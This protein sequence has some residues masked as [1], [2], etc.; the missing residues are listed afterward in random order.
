MAAVTKRLGTV[1]I[2]GGDFDCTPEELLAIWNQL[3]MCFSVIRVQ[4]GFHIEPGYPNTTSMYLLVTISFEAR[5]E[6][7]T[8]LTFAEMAADETGM[9]AAL[10]SARRCG[11]DHRSDTFFDRGKKL[12]GFKSDPLYNG[13]TS[14]ARAIVAMDVGRDSVT[15]LSEL[16]LTLRPCEAIH[17]RATFFNQILA[18]KCVSHLSRM[19]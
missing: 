2:L 11:I 14:D 15:L 5:H 3:R 8:P 13:L 7:G 1:C 17:E 10:D 18:A 4:N 12:L 6:D 16:R 19:I 9:E